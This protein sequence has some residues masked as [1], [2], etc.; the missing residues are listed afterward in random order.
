MQVLDAKLCTVNLTIYRLVINTVLKTHELTEMAPE[1]SVLSREQVVV[2]LVNRKRR[3]ETIKELP[4]TI[5]VEFIM[6]PFTIHGLDNISAV[7]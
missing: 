2:P 3:F 1:S 5:A 6:N 7:I 4:H